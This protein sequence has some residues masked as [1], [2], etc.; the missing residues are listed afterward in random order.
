MHVE[1]MSPLMGEAVKHIVQH[2]RMSDSNEPGQW[3]YGSSASN[4]SETC[5]AEPRNFSHREY[6]I[7]TWNVVWTMKEYNAKANVATSPFRFDVCIFADEK[8]VETVR[9]ASYSEAAAFIEET[10]KENSEI[11]QKMLNLAQKKIG[12]FKEVRTF[13]AYP[14]ETFENTDAIRRKVFDIFAEK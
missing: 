4:I 13:L 3:V 7:E 5:V 14:P 12:N 6:Q 8:K 1:V 2:D 9:F 11:Y 10:N